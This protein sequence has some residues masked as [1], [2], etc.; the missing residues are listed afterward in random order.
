MKNCLIL[1]LGHI[2]SSGRGWWCAK[3]DLGFSRAPFCFSSTV[4]IHH[5]VDHHSK[6][7]ISSV[8]NRVVLAFHFR[9]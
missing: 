6:R 3:I 2:S 4:I 7:F 1:G 5:P 9:N 8:Y